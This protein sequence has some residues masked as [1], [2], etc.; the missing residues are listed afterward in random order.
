MGCGEISVLDGGTI[1]NTSL[2]NTQMVN[3]T[4]QSSALD[5]S[6]ITNLNGVDAV[7]AQRIADA[8][9]ALT[10]E[11]LA[12][13]MRALAQKQTIVPAAAPATSESNAVPTEFHGDREVGMGA[14]D[15]WAQYS[16][17]YVVPL[18]EK[19]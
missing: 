10:P 9:A 8:I 13:L 2:V 16:D 1:K 14:P 19:R 11:Q 17:D 12:G 4:I 3:S 6:S 15:M 5:G 7:S 18:Y